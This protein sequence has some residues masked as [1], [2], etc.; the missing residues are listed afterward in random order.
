MKKVFIFLSSS[1]GRTARFITGSVIS[2]V[3]LFTSPLLV[4]VG[5]VPFLAAIFDFCVFAPLFKLPF[6]GKKLREAL[7]K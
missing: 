1:N 5:L 7:N 2:A 4:A 3:G 6:E